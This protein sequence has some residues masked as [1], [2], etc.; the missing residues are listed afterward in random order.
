MQA[1]DDDPEYSYE[2]LLKSVKLMSIFPGPSVTNFRKVVPNSLTALANAVGL[3]A[4]VLG[5]QGQFEFAVLC[6][7]GAGL[8][9]GLDGPTARALGGTSRFGAEFDSLSDYVNFGVSPG[10][11]LYHWCLYKY[12]WIGWLTTLTYIICMG[13]RL[14]RFNAGVDYNASKFTRNFFMGVPA[15]GGAFLVVMPLIWT[16]AFRD[17]VSPEF[18]KQPQIIFPYTIIV[19]LL[20]VSR[21]PTFSSK[22]LNRT[23]L[24]RM[25]K[26]KTLGILVTFFAIVAIV[27]TRPWLVF[28]AT[29]ICYLF[30]FPGSYVA[31]VALTSSAL[32][33]LKQGKQKNKN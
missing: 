30:S 31:F 10:L 2:T 28:T 1:D 12:G 9:D 21:I 20:L 25:G 24:G 16:F 3:S 8:L 26:R 33:K 6:V 5:L 13:C 7:M 19:A 15:P 29:G 23:I 4:I 14:A 11:L 22:M 18:F 32:K 27:I 17:Y